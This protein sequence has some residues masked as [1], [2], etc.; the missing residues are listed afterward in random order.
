MQPHFCHRTR[1]EIWPNI[2]DLFNRIREFLA[3]ILYDV[4]IMSRDN[5]YLCVCV[6][7]RVKEKARCICPAACL[8]TVIENIQLEFQFGSHSN[9]SNPSIVN[10]NICWHRSGDIFFAFRLWLQWISPFFGCFLFSFGPLFGVFVCAR[11]A[12]CMCM[13]NVLINYKS[14]INLWTEHC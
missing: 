9:E 1:I 6:C 14:N 10:L 2:C 3:C 11:C 8:Y 4:M 13:K 5:H 12:R 7:V